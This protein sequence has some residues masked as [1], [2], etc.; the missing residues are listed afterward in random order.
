L[1]TEVGSV[2]WP[3]DCP[4]AAQIEVMVR[5][6]CLDCHPSENGQGNIVG[7]EFRGAFYL[8]KV[9]LPSG[10]IVR[11]LLPH[12]QE[13][14]VGSKVTVELRCGHSLRPFVDGR[15]VAD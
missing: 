2:V 1:T 6:D 10:N 8:Y 14:T 3:E 15:A 11:C 13:Y 4:S 12:T 5:P 9:S 7:R